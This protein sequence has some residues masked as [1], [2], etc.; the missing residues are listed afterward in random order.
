MDYRDAGVDVEAGRSFVQRIRTLV[1]STRRPE[2]LGGMGGFSGLCALPSGY[3]EPVLVSGTDGVGTKLKIAQITQR[4]STVGIDLVA[5]CVNDILTSGAE[6]LF[7]LDYLA[8]GKLEPAALGEV[9]EGIVAGCR[10]A[11]CA[12]LGGETAEMPGFY[13][14]GEY[15]L[16]GF[17]VGVVEKSQILDGSQVQVGDRIIGLASSGV[18]SNGFSLVRK[19]VAEGRRADAN[20]G[21]TWDETVPALGN[22][23]LGEI[24]LTP[25][26]IY[27]EPILKARRAG[28][29]I[30]GMAHITGGGLPENLPRCLGA[31][32]SIHIYGGSWPVP[33]VFSWLAET[34][35][36]PTAD[37][38]NTFN[39]GLG[40]A[41]VVPPQESDR[42]LAW[43]AEHQVEAYLVGE[44]T[45]GSGEV[46]GLI[47]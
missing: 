6:P 39:M 9:V 19:V 7:F 44:V 22:H 21:Y 24:F 13:G 12:L 23:S 42:A 3:R 29:T 41:L 27:V 36:V 26:R 4:H 40:F 8:T 46:T 17:C 31:D 5:M 20:V 15:D 30:H 25:T 47:E 43:L 2:V 16:A 11:G 32:Q 38:Y 37:L 33:S 28:L 10:L 35:Q 18:H 45:A 14:P 1:D 34:G